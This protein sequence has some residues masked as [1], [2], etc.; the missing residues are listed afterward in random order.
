MRIQ[1]F[2]RVWGAFVFLSDG[3]KDSAS[4]L[5]SE[6]RTQKKQKANSSQ[7]RGYGYTAH[8]ALADCAES[9]E[10]GA[11]VRWINRGTRARDGAGQ[12]TDLALARAWLQS[13][14]LGNRKKQQRKL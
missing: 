13:P 4:R 3:F 6:L 12:S 5:S 14:A 1:I 10:T 8:A 2:I 7:Y 9:L 11:V